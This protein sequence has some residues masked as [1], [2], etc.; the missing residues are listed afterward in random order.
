MV[1]GGANLVDLMGNK[2]AAAYSALF[3]GDVASGGDK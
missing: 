1:V 3:G 2:D